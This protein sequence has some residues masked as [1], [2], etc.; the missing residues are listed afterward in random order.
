MAGFDNACQLLQPLGC[1]YNAE[2]EASQL[3]QALDRVCHVFGCHLLPLLIQDGH[4]LLLG[5]DTARCSPCGLYVSASS[6]PNEV[7]R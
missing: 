6:P 5:K 3:G 2:Q 4:D 7:G 1:S